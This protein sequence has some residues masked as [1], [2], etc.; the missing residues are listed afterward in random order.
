[1]TDGKNDHPHCIGKQVFGTKGDAL[2]LLR[3]RNK[4]RKRNAR[5]GDRFDGT[6]DAYRC[7]C[8]GKWHLGN[9]RR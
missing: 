4:R 1:M 9:N 2:K 8:C 7:S 5:R 6:L 3:L